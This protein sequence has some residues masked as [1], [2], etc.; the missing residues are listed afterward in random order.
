[1]DMGLASK[2]QYGVEY[3]RHMPQTREDATLMMD[4]RTQQS[5]HVNR[6]FA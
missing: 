1:M 3:G 4:I 5:Q 2:S 6:D